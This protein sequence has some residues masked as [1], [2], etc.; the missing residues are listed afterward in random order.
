[1]DS[2]QVAQLV[3]YLSSQNAKVKAEALEIVLQLT[4]EKENRDMLRQSEV[5]K[6]VLRAVPE[7]VRI[8][9]VSHS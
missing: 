6:L 8:S 9:T 2:S 4:G 7:Q 5:T 1:M 3:P